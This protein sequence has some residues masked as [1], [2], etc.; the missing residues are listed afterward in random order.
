MELK[1]IGIDLAKEVF[2][3]HGTDGQGREMMRKRVYRSDML[4]TFR[5]L[6]ACRV[7]MES[8]AGSNYWARELEKLGHQVQLIAPQYVKP[9][10]QRNKNDSKDAEAICTAARQPH[11]RYVPRRSIEQ[12]DLQNLHRIRE[13]MVKARTALV[14]EVRG[15]LCEYGIIIPRG[16]QTF[17]NCIGETLLKNSV[18]LTSLAQETF[19]EL[20][21]EYLQLDKR[22]EALE[23]K[24]KTICRAHPVCQRLMSI[25]GV[26]FLTAT[27]VIAAI[28]DAHAFRNGRELAAWLGLTPREHS[29]GGKHRLLGISKRGDCYIRKLL[30]HGARITLRYLN[31]HNDRRSAWAADL[32][33]RKGANRTAV[34]LAN[35]NARVIWA[36]V[37]K[38]EEYRKIPLAA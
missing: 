11:M 19:Y 26:G 15:L 7:V 20:W 30:I 18:Y 12:Q 37:A 22:I 31:R 32:L 6:T 16:R 10:V 35:K 4:A 23:K 33:K 5:N 34:A 25:P 3:L 38:D 14:N 28:G 27:A 1:L 36:L 17:A 29:T 13:R 8:C 21:D 9:Y 24:L 2:H